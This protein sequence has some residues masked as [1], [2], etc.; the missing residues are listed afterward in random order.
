MRR[1]L[2]ISR[3][4]P[5]AALRWSN[6]DIGGGQGTI[7]RIC[8]N[9]GEFRSQKV[10]VKVEIPLVIGAE[11]HQR[12][13]APVRGRQQVESQL[14][15]RWAGDRNHVRE[16][17]PAQRTGRVPMLGRIAGQRLNMQLKG[18]EI[19]VFEGGGQNT[20]DLVE[21]GRHFEFFDRA[22]H[23]KIV[24]DDLAL[25]DG[26]LRHPPQF[27]KLQVV[28]MLDTQPD[29]GAH[30]G[31]HKSQRTSGRPQQEQTEQSKQC[32]DSVQNDDNLAMREKTKIRK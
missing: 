14:P 12:T 29:A 17:A 5:A 20:A 7:E 1:Q 6:E 27:A 25:L 9:N 15:G 32:R 24:D 30:H 31:E 8:Q 19:V 22:A 18:V 13:A 10:D 26:A 11:D 21:V 23:G 2:E 28:Q 16:L 4:I 3:Q